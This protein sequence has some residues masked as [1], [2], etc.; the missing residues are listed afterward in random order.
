M[1]K[2]GA[3]RRDIEE[4]EAKARGLIA[5]ILPLLDKLPH[6]KLPEVSAHLEAALAAAR[7][8]ADTERMVNKREKE[9]V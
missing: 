2:P 3:R 8:K 4:A 6:D 9:A 5:D 1:S 7:A